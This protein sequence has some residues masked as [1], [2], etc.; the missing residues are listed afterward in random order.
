MNLGYVFEHGDAV[1]VSTFMLLVLMS[2]ASWYVI[3]WKYCK[4]HSERRRLR[5]FRS[6]AMTTRDWPLHL[7]AAPEKGSVAALLHGWEHTRPVLA[8]HSKEEQ[9]DVLSTHLAQVLDNVRVWLDKGLTILASIGATAPFIG[10]FGT[11]W[12]VYNALMA[13]ADAGNARLDVVAGPM[14]EALVMTAVGL[15]AA[16]PAVLAFNLFG[17]MNRVLVQDLRHVAEDIALYGGQK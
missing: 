3:V 7:Q 8:R 2:A 9:R 15:F 14:G 4:L 12:G 6:E 11:V 10:L 5:A 1:L 16:I 13:V 17:R